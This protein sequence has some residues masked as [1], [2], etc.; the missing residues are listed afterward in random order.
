MTKAINALSAEINQL[1]IVIN[2]LAFKLKA[3]TFGILVLM[4]A[5]ATVGGCSHV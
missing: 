5:V 1:T 4:V 3:F 2:S